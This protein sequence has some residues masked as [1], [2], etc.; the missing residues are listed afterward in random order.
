[1]PVF[2][3]TIFLG[4]FLLFLVQP[5]IGKYLL[6]WFGG[7]PSVWTTCLFFFQVFLVGG[8]AYG[9]ALTRFCKPRTQTIIHLGIL[10]VALACLPIVPSANWKPRTPDHPAANI[11]LLLACN[12]GVPFLVLAVTGPLLQ[13]WSS[14]FNTQKSPYRLYALSNLGSLLA[15]LTYPVLFEAHLSRKSQALFWEWSFVLYTVGCAF[16]AL[17]TGTLGSRRG[18]SETPIAS[19]LAAAP[20][21]PGQR[22]LWLLWSACSSVLL[23]ATTNKL[24]LDVAVF[25]LLWV[26]PLAS[27]LTSFVLCFAGPRAYLRQPFTLA[28]GVAMVGFCWALFQG[29]G[30]PFWNQVLVYIS[31]LFVCCVVCHG[32]LFRIRPAPGALTEFYLLIALGG[33]LG[34]LFVSVVAPLIFTH[35]YE[36]HWGL[37]LCAFLVASTRTHEMVR[38]LLK[39]PD[40]ET[41][42][43]AQANKI[44]PER[45]APR[46]RGL[47]LASL[48]L[49]FFATAATLWIQGRRVNSDIVLKSRNFYGVLTFFEHRKDEPTG[50]HFL[51]QHGRITHGLQ[52]VHAQL[53]SWPTTYYGTESGLGLALNALP[54]GERRV[55]VVGLG[56]GTIAAYAQPGDFFAFYE[57]NPQVSCLATSRFT[58]LTGC[59]GKWEITPGDARLALEQQH[60]QGFDLV[61][62][63]AFNSDSIPVHL[64]TRE[65]FAVYLRHLKTNGVL[66]VHISNHFLNLEPVVAGLA[67]HFG[68]AMAVIDHDAKLE[69]WWIY[70]STWILLSRD[71][72]ILSGPSIRSASKTDHDS[73]ATERLWTD[74]FSSLFQILR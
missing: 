14:H 73:N 9:H 64:L 69:Q 62:L 45:N 70:S 26:L 8:Y 25:P 39:G 20:V 21:R 22:L 36:L 5:L 65:A 17:S 41:I 44:V 18:V 29:A 51:L 71:P 59:R 53:Q 50:D 1:M 52:F 3:F 47:A 12:L 10:L 58:Y 15:L 72:R 48:W 57:I 31:A 6:P 38:T 60:P 7:G 42:G 13:L 63:D 23:M 19:D 56:A 28:F 24:C 35:Y 2:A 66:A 27:Y 43:L 16:C 37:V 40:F 11:L 61:A 68:L 74:D 34:G 54:P 33:A 32:E 4:A 49:F 67:R 30:W 55:G 46:W